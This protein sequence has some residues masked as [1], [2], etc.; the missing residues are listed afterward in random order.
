MKRLVLKILVHLIVVLTS[1]LMLSGCSVV[2]SLRMMN[3]NNDITPVLPNSTDGAFKQ[4]IEAVYI[5]EKPYIKVK[6]NDQEELL[7]LIDTGAS[8]TMLFDTEKVARLDVKRGFSLKIAGWGDGDDSPAFQTEL[9]SIE[10]GG[11]RFDEVKVA[12]IPLSTT[13]FYLSPDEGIFDGVLGHD[14]LR[15]FNW[16]FD[17]QAKQITLA[18]SSYNVQSNDVTIPFETFFS[19]LSMPIT[20]HIDGRDFNQDV[21]IDTGSRHYFKFNTQFVKNHDIQLPQV[22]IQASDFGLSGEAKHERIRL[23]GL[24]LGELKLKG[25]KA[26]II[27]AEDEDDYWVIGSALMN[28]FVTIIDYKNEVMV[29]RPYPGV[30]FKTKYNLAGLDLRKLT[31]GWL[32]VRQT[33]PGQVSSQ[34]GLSVGAIVTSI[35]G[36]STKQISE[37]NWLEMASVPGSFE[38][39]FQ[40]QSCR[41]ITTKHIEGYSTDGQSL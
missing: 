25:I 6:V 2:N 13:P 16:M 11:A 36:V 38:L 21:F 18:S 9:A 32:I 24:S 3:A 7:F 15:H 5:G 39:C 37:Q 26:N 31:S 1:V 40:D 8:F 29:F 4:A 17:K 23:S 30:S 35:N 27:E 22:S 20:L 12:Y 41:R 19:K 28:Q 10:M 34:A 33:F 14:L